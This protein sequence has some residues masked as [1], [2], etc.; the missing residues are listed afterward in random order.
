MVIL[1]LKFVEAVIVSGETCCQYRLNR[2]ERNRMKK[3]NWNRSHVADIS[4]S[5][6]KSAS[7]N[8]IPV[9]Q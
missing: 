4:L 6:R 3:I 7:R 8:Q 1:T 9:S 2:A 5:M